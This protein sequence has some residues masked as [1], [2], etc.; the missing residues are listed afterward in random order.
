MLLFGAVVA[1][2]DSCLNGTWVGIIDDIEEVWTL[3]KL[4]IPRLCLRQHFTG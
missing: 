2:A 1:S 4:M 3:K